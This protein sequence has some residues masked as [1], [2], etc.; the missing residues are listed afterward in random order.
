MVPGASL[1]SN[2]ARRI[3]YVRKDIWLPVETVF[4]DQR[5][6]PVKTAWYEGFERVQD[7]WTITRMRVATARKGTHTVVTYEDIRFNTGLADS[8]FDKN[9]L[10]R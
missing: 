4:F 3:L 5:G 2:Y 6:D 7:I 1:N 9:N 10:K 8:L